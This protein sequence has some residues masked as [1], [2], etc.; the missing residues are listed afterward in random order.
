MFDPESSRNQ[1]CFCNRNR[2]R[3]SNKDFTYPKWRYSGKMAKSLISYV[4]PPISVSDANPTNLPSA[5]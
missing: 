1:A 2:N 4:P 3:K 5:K